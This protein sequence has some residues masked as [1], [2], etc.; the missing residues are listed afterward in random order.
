LPKPVLQ[1]FCYQ[2]K[3][4]AKGGKTQIKKGG[5]NEDLGLFKN[6]CLINIGGLALC[7]RSVIGLSPGKLLGYGLRP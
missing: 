7:R 5:S 4:L 1:L 3:L 6:Y 2:D